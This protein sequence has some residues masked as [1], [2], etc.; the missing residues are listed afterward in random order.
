MKRPLALLIAAA[1]VAFVGTGCG[2][3]HAGLTSTLNDAAT[4][5]YTVKGSVHTLH[6]SRDELLSEVAS[7]V[8][9]KP[10]N[11]F[12]TQNSF[13]VSRDLSADT[14]VTAIWLS[15][16]ISQQAIDALFAS[17]SLHVTAT[18]RTQASKDVVQIFPAADIFSKFSAKFQATLID[19]QARSEALLASY[20]ET[21]D[22]AGQAYFNAHQSQFG[23]A[24]GKDVA[25]ILVATK[26]AAQGIMTQLASGASFAT[27]AQQD[28]TDKQSGAKGGS[29]GCLAA[30]EFVAPFQKAADAATLGKPVGPVKSQF[31]YHIILV[32]KSVTT[33]DS[34]R[35]QVQQALKQVGS[36]DT[37]AAVTAL[38]K[39]FKVHLDARFGTWGPV[40]NGQGGT[41]YQVT[42]PTTPTPSSSREGSTTT[43]GPTVTTAPTSSGSP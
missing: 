38:L 9:N 28:S 16:L 22:A 21:S 30:S 43:T 1:L 17:R 5:R 20:T 37:Q 11:T 27:L 34:V 39:S 4:L 25:H 29:L 33:Y 26:A 3:G 6:V 36:T 14:R 24:S 8:A 18:V 23:C 12:L 10:F 2:S 7:I 13:P 42:A 19:R 32:T 40:S 15:Q 35:A 31:G 41:A